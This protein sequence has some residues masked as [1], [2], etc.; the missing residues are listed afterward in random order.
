MGMTIDAIVRTKTLQ[1]PLGPPASV[2]LMPKHINQ[3]FTM[4]QGYNDIQKRRNPN[5]PTPDKRTRRRKH[6]KKNTKNHHHASTSIVD[7][8]LIEQKQ[9]RRL[10]LQHEMGQAMNNLKEKQIRFKKYIDKRTTPPKMKKYKIMKHDDYQNT[11]QPS[12]KSV[13]DDVKRKP[14]PSSLLVEQKR[15]YFRH[16]VRLK[17]KRSQ[18]R[19]KEYLKWKKKQ[20]KKKKERKQLEK[21][22][23]KQLAKKRRKRKK[24]RKKKMQNKQKH[25]F[26]YTNG[27]TSD[28][29]DDNDEDES[30]F[31]LSSTTDSDDD[32]D[33][34]GVS[35]SSSGTFSDFSSLDDDDDYTTSS[36]GESDMSFSSDGTSNNNNN[37]HNSNE[38]SMEDERMMNHNNL[39][40][41]KFVN[42]TSLKQLKKMKQNIYAKVNEQV[43]NISRKQHNNNNDKKS[44]LSTSLHYSVYNVRRRRKKK[45]KKNMK[46]PLPPMNSPPSNVK[47]INVIPSRPRLPD[48]LTLRRRNEAE[49]VLLDAAID[50]YRSTA[51]TAS[52][53]LPQSTRPRNSQVCGL[54][55]TLLSSPSMNGSMADSYTTTSNNNE[56]P[57]TILK[58]Q[59]KLQ[60][61]TLPE[62]KSI[63]EIRKRLSPI[64]TPT[65]K[66]GFILNSPSAVVDID[67]KQ[68]KNLLPLSS[69]TK[70]SKNN[71]KRQRS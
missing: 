18:R 49:D 48:L 3:Q 34:S 61:H 2:I 58:R 28:H 23:R 42:I 54:K 13:V 63:E 52:L 30:S 56:T 47:K 46:K 8:I 31:D 70:R 5:A 45:T 6:Q 10:K 11:P 25:K 29:N 20:K 67:G 9:N 59:R 12:N 43:H 64:S 4:Q 35:S 62:L 68:K 37:N 24:K 55:G 41:K 71:N 22:L 14:I 26:K 39:K 16:K 60:R 32:E 40:N 65:H 66:W 7:Q 19:K 53:S 17:R 50:R 36:D 44:P 1:S 15:Q 51:L 38:D 21:I 69:P 57:R 33:T 27:K